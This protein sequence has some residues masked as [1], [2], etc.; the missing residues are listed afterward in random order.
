MSVDRW[1]TLNRREIKNIHLYSA[2]AA[3]GGWA[4]LT[5]A[6]LGRIGGIVAREY[7]YLD[8]FARQ[9]RSPRFPR[10]GRV[11]SRAMLY[12][13]AGRRTYHL[14]DERVQLERGMRQERNVQE[15]NPCTECV[16]QTARGWVAI[17][18]LVVIGDRLC[19]SNCRC[20][21]EYR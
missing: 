17:G 2:A 5:Q 21:L 20:R 1:R 19:L 4:Q 6:E 8:A 7:R 16:E 12:A 15:R 13:Q 9:L 18:S 10:D 14:T 11:L 3:R